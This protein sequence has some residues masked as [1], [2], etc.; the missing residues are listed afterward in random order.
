MVT[1]IAEAGVNHNGRLELALALVDAAADAGADIVKFQ[2]FEAAAL[3]TG[4]AEK[5]AYQKETTGAGQSQLAMLRALEL[6]LAAHRTIVERCKARGIGFLSTPF[7]AGSLSL[8]VDDLGVDRLK[9]G[10]GDM[11]NA[12]HVLAVARTGRDVI[13]STGMA[14]IDEIEEALGV[15]AF[16]YANASAP[17][18]RAAFRAA[19]ASPALKANLAR[20]VVVLH[21]TTAYPTPPA[22]INLGAMSDLARRLG[23]PVGFS[24]HSDGLAVPIAAAALGAVMIEKHITLDRSMPGPD[25]RASLDPGQFAAMVRGIRDATAALGSGIKARAGIEVA[26]MAAA[27]KSVVAAR[28]IAAGEPF[29]TDALTTKRPGNGLAPV[30]L[31]DLIGRPARRAYAADELIAE[32]EISSAA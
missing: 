22:S 18:S 6:D 23:L 29:T 2:T 7:D 30:V 17:P 4:T 27:R 15:L 28:P 8:L 25:H 21:C 5:A 1:V 19:L 24:D 10:S 3:V 11:N 32:A 26:N 16:G 31:F 13:L 14:T 20:K 12:P 9:I